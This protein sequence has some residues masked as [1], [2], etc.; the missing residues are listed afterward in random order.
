MRFCGIIELY[1]VFWVGIPYRFKAVV[2]GFVYQGVQAGA[3]GYLLK[4]TP[5]DGIVE[6]IR[7]VEK[8]A[9]VFD[10]GVKLTAVKPAAE[11]APHYFPE[12]TERE[13]EILTHVAA[14]LSNNE[15]AEKL[16]LSRGTVRNCVPVILEKLDL[17]DRTQLAVFCWKNNSRQQ[18][19]FAVCFIH[20]E[21]P[22]IDGS[23]LDFSQNS[24]QTFSLANPTSNSIYQKIGYRPV[25]DSVMLKFG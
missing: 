10:K 4:S 18:P 25:C 14:G 6:R 11:P 22:P 1:R 24:N 17:R 16:F 3:E 5:A 19:D 9:Y 2:E 13:N 8:G 23:A 21:V 7:A 20:K 15:I 12:L